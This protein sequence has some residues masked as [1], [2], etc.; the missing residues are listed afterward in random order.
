M[1][2]TAFTLSRATA[3]SYPCKSLRAGA[4]CPTRSTSRSSMCALYPMRRF[5]SPAIRTSAVARDTSTTWI[6]RRLITGQPL[7]ARSPFACRSAT[8]RRLATPKRMSTSDTCTANSRDTVAYSTEPCTVPRG[9]TLFR[10]CPSVSTSPERH[11]IQN[12]RLSTGLGQRLPVAPLPPNTVTAKTIGQGITVAGPERESQAHD[13]ALRNWR[14]RSTP[15]EYCP[16]PRNT[17]RTAEKAP[18]RREAGRGSASIPTPA[19]PSASA[20][21]TADKTRLQGHGPRRTRCGTPLW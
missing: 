18:D 8:R 21:P 13:R 17:Q 3:S 4:T 20:S 10:T 7:M 9:L 14:R 5:R 2:V 1:E 12:S 6:G 16:P 11:P 15:Q 19:A